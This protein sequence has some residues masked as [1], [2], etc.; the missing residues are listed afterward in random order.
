MKGLER[1]PD[2]DGLRELGLSSMEET[3]RRSDALYNYLKGGSY[4]EL[5]SSAVSKVR[6]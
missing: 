1:M 5:V 4:R 3:E 2:E 6:E